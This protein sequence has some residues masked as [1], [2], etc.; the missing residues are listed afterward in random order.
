MRYFP[1]YRGGMSIFIHISLTV[2][3][4]PQDLVNDLV[5]CGLLA[6]ED[7]LN[8]IDKLTEAFNSFNN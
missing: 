1:L 2:D 5:N 4:T 6:I 8:V 3:D 7:K